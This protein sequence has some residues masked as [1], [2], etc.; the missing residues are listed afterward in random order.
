MPGIQ[1]F[2]DNGVLQIDSA[3]KN[4]ALKYKATH[5]FSAM[6]EVPFDCQPGDIIAFSNTSA[7][8]AV[9]KRSNRFTL[10]FALGIASG[11]LT[12]YIFGYQDNPSSNSAGMQVFDEHGMVA[13]D[14][15]KLYMRVVGMVA[16]QHIHQDVLTF[17]QA[18][19]LS[20]R[21]NTELGRSIAMTYPVPRVMTYTEGASGDVWHNDGTSFDAVDH[22]YVGSS[23]CEIKIYRLARVSDGGM[24]IALFYQRM[25]GPAL[26]LDVANF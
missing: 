26:L 20:F 22:V 12:V 25:A 23:F 19:A 17:D 18:Q 11:Q 1:I 21:A 6:F 10:K 13:F 24:N 7:P 16:A 3:Y 14:T 15:G 2:N 9:V 8:V 4:Y 5:S